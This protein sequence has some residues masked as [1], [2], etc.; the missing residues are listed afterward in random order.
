MLYNHSTKGCQFGIKNDFVSFTNNS[1]TLNISNQLNFIIMKSIK[2]FLIAMCLSAFLLSSTIAY[3][4]DNAKNVMVET[5]YIMPVKGKEKEFE[6][7]VKLHN[8]TFHGKAPHQAGMN[9]IITGPDSGWYVWYMGPTTFTD[10][11]S[12]PTGNHDGDWAAK[13]DPLVKKYGNTEYWKYEAKSSLVPDGVTDSKYSTMWVIDLEMDSMDKIKGLLDKVIAVN[14]KKEGESMRVY[15]SR[16]NADDGRDLVMIFDF[17]KWAE[18]DEENDF[19]KR[20][21]AMNGADSFVAFLKEWRSIV[22]SN[23]EAVW[24][25]VFKE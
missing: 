8:D 11:D 9:S 7:A 25:D 22:K 13:I 5:V 12:R 6:K 14:S 2:F 15:S 20:F 1:S 4:Q 18:L 3:S 19:A 17:N 21:N 16:F 10:L 23:K 24:L